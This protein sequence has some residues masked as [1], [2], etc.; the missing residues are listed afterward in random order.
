MRFRNWLIVGGIGALG[1]YGLVCVAGVL[2]WAMGN[3]ILSSPI[4]GHNPAW[5][6][7]FN[8]QGHA[9]RANLL[10]PLQRPEGTYMGYEFLPSGFEHGKAYRLWLND[11]HQRQMAT[12][13]LLTVDNVDQLVFQ[14]NPARQYTFAVQSLRG[15]EIQFALIAEGGTQQ[16]F[17]QVVPF[18]AMATGS[19][20]CRL[21]AEFWD[22]VLV[23]LSG[24]G[25]ESG[26][27]ITWTS[28]SAGEII[29]GQ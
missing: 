22:P 29:G 17:A 7:S 16:A 26:E 14:N 23:R 9:L 13:D 10:G 2:L 4:A 15:Q 12:S 11:F 1:I 25:F 6:V 18:P 27:T 3:G 20:R 5:E 8:T 19:G 21:S 28:D 24:E